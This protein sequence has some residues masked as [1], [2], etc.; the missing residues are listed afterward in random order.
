MKQLIKQVAKVYIKSFPICINGQWLYMSDKNIELVP[1]MIIGKYERVM[2]NI[3]KT[4]VKK[5]DVVC[6]VGAYIGY[7]TNLF[8]DLV[9]PNGKVFSFEPNPHSYQLLRKNLLKYDRRNVI[10]TNV[11]VSNNVSMQRIYMA[12]DKDAPDSRLFQ[13]LGE[14]VL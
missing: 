12:K 11:A 5:D 9:E 8:S 4:I 1:A 3:I 7:Y 6:D 2:T 13:P 14:R 10:A